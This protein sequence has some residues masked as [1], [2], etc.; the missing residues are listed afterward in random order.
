M[1]EKENLTNNQNLTEMQREWVISQ[2]KVYHTNPHLAYPKNMSKIRMLIFKITSSDLFDKGIFFLICLNTLV[3]AL[4]WLLIDPYL[5]RILDTV[6]HVFTGIFTLE[7]V[8]KIIG[9]G[10]LYFKK[11]WNLFDFFIVLFTYMQIIYSSQVLG[12]GVTLHATVV[13]VL[14]FIRALRIVKKA[15][16][17]KKIALTLILTIP[18]LANIALLLFLLV[19]FYA[20][21]GMNLFGKVMLHDAL[22][23]H[24]NFQ[25]FP[26]AFL[27]M[28]R[29]ATGEGWNDI[30]NALMEQKSIRFQ[31]KEEASFY[32][33]TVASYG[34]A[35]ACGSY[36]SSLLFFISYILIVSQIF[37]NLFIAI[38]LDGFD[39][40]K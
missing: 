39:D 36:W 8:M 9:H 30:M 2:I 37:L 16:M 4:N 33:D 17:L 12:V 40:S 24:A 13:R 1:A 27:T 26:N 5:E 34:Q 31:C 38:I 15:E 3:L 21:M 19:I 10:R 6:N 25:N 32:E 11:Y 22:D 18:S 14:K 29:C 7:A 23:E 28:M 20:I 35:L